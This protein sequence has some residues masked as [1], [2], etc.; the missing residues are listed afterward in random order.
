MVARL[1]RNETRRY[2]TS[3]ASTSIEDME[4]SAFETQ[5]EA[6]TLGMGF[7]TETDFGMA[8]RELYV[9]HIRVLPGPIAGHHHQAV[10]EARPRDEKRHLVVRFPVAYDHFDN[11][12]RFDRGIVHVIYE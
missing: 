3:A 10:V 12:W 7:L 9:H 4:G 5:L 11:Q 1:D 6:K 2:Y 8:P